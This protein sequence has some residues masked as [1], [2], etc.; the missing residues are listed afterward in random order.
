MLSIPLADLPVEFDGLRLRARLLA[1]GYDITA[2][3]VEEEVLH[4]QGT[5][6]LGV[7]LGEPDRVAVLAVMAQIATD[8]RRML[9]AWTVRGNAKI[10]LD[11]DA[12]LRRATAVFAGNATFTSAG[13]Q[14]AVAALVLVASE[15]FSR[16]GTL[17]V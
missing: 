6:S 12:I 2:L 7:E 13:L 1:L 9:R 10:A 15:R 14:R 5:T 8:V 11:D 16:D 3:W 17:D 4:I